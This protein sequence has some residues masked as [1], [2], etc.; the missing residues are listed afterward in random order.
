MVRSHTGLGIRA[1]HPTGGGHG[2][3][4]SVRS[5]PSDLRIGWFARSMARLNCVMPDPLVEQHFLVIK[6]RRWRR[7]DPSIPDP[8]RVELTAELMSAR[9]AV[10]AAR[11]SG[12]REDESA[13]RRRVRDAKVSLGER[14]TPWWDRTT[15]GDRSRAASSVRA[16]LRHRGPDRSVCPSDVARILGGSDWRAVMTPVREI[17]AA[18]EDDG[19]IV[20]TQKGVAAVRPWRGPIR[21]RLPS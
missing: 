14:G 11:T 6:G 12:S 3:V 20:V 5:V 15:D 9:R 16:L 10:G 19:E 13:A 4:G 8:L 2:G 18:M 1:P 17:A 7:T 21:L